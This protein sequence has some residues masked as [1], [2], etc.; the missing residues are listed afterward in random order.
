MLRDILFSVWLISTC[1]QSNHFADTTQMVT[2]LKPNNKN[3]E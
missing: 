1:L 2:P 3:N